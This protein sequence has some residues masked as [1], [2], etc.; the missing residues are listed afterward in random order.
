ML[1]HGQM[2]PGA[3][4]HLMVTNEG[5]QFGVNMPGDSSSPPYQGG[6]PALHILESPQQV[7]PSSSGTRDVFITNATNSRADHAPLNVV[8]AATDVFTMPL[9]EG[10]EGKPQAVSS[11]FVPA[12][13]IH[14]LCLTAVR[15]ESLDVKLQRHS[16]SSDERKQWLLGRGSTVAS[17]HEETVSS[18]LV[19]VL[20]NNHRHRH[21]ESSPK[22]HLALYGMWEARV[23]SDSSEAYV[24]VFWQGLRL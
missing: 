2:P 8:V 5:R 7:P 10:K 18:L 19:K 13:K 1:K 21:L 17:W 4:C 23:V 16:G 11:A 20:T 24:V 9:R 22:H 6:P 12:F 3:G 14:L 15:G